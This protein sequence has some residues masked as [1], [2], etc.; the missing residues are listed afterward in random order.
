M[1]DAKTFSVQID[2]E[3]LAV[4]DDVVEAVANIGLDALRNVVLMSPVDEG[5]F[6]GNWHTTIGTTSNAVFDRV[7]LTGAK[8]IN[9]GARTLNAYEKLQPI[10]IQNNLPYA[11]R[12][13]NG[14]SG[15]APNGMV[16]LTVN[17]IEAKYKTTEV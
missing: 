2:E 3:W 8:T 15:Q 17:Y 13:E 6:R 9:D 1:S 11:Q 12:L 7:D 14:H 10:Y 4:Q 5:R 16:A